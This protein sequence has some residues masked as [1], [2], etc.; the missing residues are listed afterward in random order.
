MPTAYAQIIAMPL[1]LSVKLFFIA[2]KTEKLAAIPN[3]QV[4]YLLKFFLLINFG[5]RNLT[6]KYLLLPAVSHIHV[7]NSASYY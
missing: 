5:C 3:N 4:H 2:H 7:S 1:F 6:M